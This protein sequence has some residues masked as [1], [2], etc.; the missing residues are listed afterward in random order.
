MGKKPS[1]SGID[2]SLA[3]FLL[4]CFSF[5]EG[6]LMIMPSGFRKLGQHNEVEAGNRYDL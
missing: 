3:G 1:N 5:I 4:R 6:T 2:R